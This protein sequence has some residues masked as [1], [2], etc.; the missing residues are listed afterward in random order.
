M[1]QSM[2]AFEFEYQ[3][4]VVEQR[5]RGLKY[6]QTLCDEQIETNKLTAKKIDVEASKELIRRSQLQLDKAKLDNDILEQKVI[7]TTDNLSFEK[8]MTLINRESLMVQGK[9]AVLKL[10][11]AK[12]DFEKNNKLFQLKYRNVP[13]I[14]FNSLGL[15]GGR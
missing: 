10:Q 15:S 9:D 2:T 12:I 8:A 5:I 14:E 7:Q 3:T 1:P 11:Q 13:Q 6:E 4:E